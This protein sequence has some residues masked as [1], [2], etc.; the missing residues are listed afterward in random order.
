MAKK[1]TR[2]T[3]TRGEKFAKPKGGQHSPP[4]VKEA[5]RQGQKGAKAALCTCGDSWEEGS[6][7]GY[8]GRCGGVFDLSWLCDCR[9]P[10]VSEVEQDWCEAC[11]GGLV[12]VAAVLNGR[13]VKRVVEEAPQQSKIDGLL[14]RRDKPSQAPHLIIEALAGTGKTTTLVEGLRY[15]LGEEP[16]ITPSSQQEAIWQAMGE[17]PKPSSIAFVAFNKSIATELQQRVPQ[18]CSASTMHSMGL[19]AVTAA[20]GRLKIDSHRVEN[21][22][23]GLL[24]CDIREMQKQYPMFVPAVKKLVGLCKQNLAG[25]PD[26]I[27]E[28]GYAA[29]ITTIDAAV[30][31]Q[32]CSHYDVE[33]GEDVS[34]VYDLVPV[35]LQACLN[36]EQDRTID[37]DDMIWLPVVLKLPVTRYD[38]LLVDEA[39]DLNKC[40]Q[41]LAM[42]VGKR[43]ILCGDKNQA[44]YGFAGADCESLPRMEELLRRTDTG[45][46]VLPLTVTRRCGK[47]IVEEAK[48]IVPTF[49]AHEDNSEGKIDNAK[50][51]GEK[52]YQDQVQDEDL[53]LCRTNAPLVSQCLRFIGRGRKATIAGRD[54]G[55][56]LIST[57]KQLKATDVIDLSSRLSEWYSRECQKE[58][59][60]RNPRESRLIA[61]QD[62]YEC[63]QYFIEDA[64][65]VEEVIEKIEK[66]FTDNSTGGIR[67][68]SIHKAKGHEADR[69]FFL[70]PKW[71]PCPHPMAKSDWQIKQEWNIKYVGITRAK[72]L[73]VYVS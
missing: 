56:G 69:V 33:I 41:Q 35:V 68:S 2:K 52:S 64:K 53:I 36:V 7:E 29:A 44:I 22:I 59:A 12:D 62:R 57:I 28:Y 17:G 24:D 67:L 49:E 66:I 40:Q 58:R 60:K 39:Q 48:K 61:L 4:G 21:I 45:V 31:D 47:A 23:S 50:Y 8:C 18:G 20:F 3:D 65:T 51:E 55:T 32:L 1:T 42:L 71:A 63:L 73:L 30:L 54:I 16:R 11:G 38:L 14:Q 6:V 34:K 5:L 72:N 43:L 46:K 70:I 27:R 15:I 25:D 26:V 9:K 37:F 19:K 10:T 13:P